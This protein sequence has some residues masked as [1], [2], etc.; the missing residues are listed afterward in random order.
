M[1]VELW[2]LENEISP[3]ILFA[4]ELTFFSKILKLKNSFL[5][6]VLSPKS[7][8]CSLLISIIIPVR[9]TLSASLKL[10]VWLPLSNPDS[11]IE[12]DDGFTRRTKLS[13]YELS[14]SLSLIDDSCSFCL[15]SPD[16]LTCVELIWVPSS[17]SDRV[18]L[19]SFLN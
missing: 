16:L 7:F 14:K 2:I 6:S 18:E 17:G 8:S 10:I 15:Q 4:I 11:F 5:P 9:A 3:I 1:S 13:S 12:S 19:L